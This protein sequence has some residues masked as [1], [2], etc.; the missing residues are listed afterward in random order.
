MRNSVLIS[1]VFFVIGPCAIAQESVADSGRSKSNTEMTW[2]PVFPENFRKGLFRMSF[3]ISNNHITGFLLIKKTSDTSTSIV[4]S[5]EFGICFF[6]FEFINGKFYTRM[7]FPSFDKKSL[8]TLLEKD[9]RLLLFSGVPGMKI[10]IINDP[11]E[12]E[13]VYKVSSVFGT[14]LYYIDIHTNKIKEIRSGHSISGKSI[15]EIKQYSAEIP[16]TIDIRHS[17]PKIRIKITGLST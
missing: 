12:D 9:F 16:G 6:H 14:F 7:I 5:N 15:L 8:L 3:D 1:L 10:K 17:V 13:K 2:S 4:F 11:G